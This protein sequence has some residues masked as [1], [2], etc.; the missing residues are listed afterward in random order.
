[1]V[2]RAARGSGQAF[3]MKAADQAA[4]KVRMPSAVGFKNSLVTVQKGEERLK[5]P[6]RKIKGEKPFALMQIPRRSAVREQGILRGGN[7]LRYAFQLHPRSTTGKDEMNALF[8]GVLQRV[9]VPLGN[10]HMI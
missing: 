9:T 1:M 6:P 2:R 5:V 10:G 3:V 4:L 8:R 7:L